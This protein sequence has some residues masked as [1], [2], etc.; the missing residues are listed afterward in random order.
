MLAAF[1]CPDHLEGAV[2][3]DG[4]LARGYTLECI[5]ESSELS[6]PKKKSTLI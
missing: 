4:F 5:K 2:V 1:Q 6:N 3:A